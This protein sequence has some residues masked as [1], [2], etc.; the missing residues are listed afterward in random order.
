MEAVKEFQSRDIE[1]RKQLLQKL[2]TAHPNSAFIIA[3][4]ADTRVQKLDKYKFT[5]PETCTWSEFLCVLRKRIGLNPDEALFV[6][7]NNTLPA[8]IM[9][10]GE[11]SQQAAGPDGFIVALYC[12]EQTFG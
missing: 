12:K 8:S 2:K 1:N 9:T 6:F 10:M 5:M 7:V 4:R 11:L 3:D